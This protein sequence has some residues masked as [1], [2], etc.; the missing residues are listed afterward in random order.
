MIICNTYH[1]K[2]TLFGAKLRKISYITRVLGAESD[3]KVIIGARFP[4]FCQPNVAEM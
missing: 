3:K 2:I 4:Y 1:K